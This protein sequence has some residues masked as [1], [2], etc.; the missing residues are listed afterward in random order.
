MMRVLGKAAQRGNAFAQTATRGC[1]GELK[2]KKP[3]P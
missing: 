1:A 2:E 3:R